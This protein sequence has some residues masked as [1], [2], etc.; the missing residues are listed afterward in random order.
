MYSISFTVRFWSLGSYQ[1]KRFHGVRWLHETQILFEEPSSGVYSPFNKVQL[2]DVHVYST[3]VGEG[4]P[5]SRD[6]EVN[7]FLGSPYQPWTQT[8]QTLSPFSLCFWIL[9]KCLF[10]VC[11]PCLG[12]KRVCVTVLVY[13]SP[14]VPR[15]RNG[16]REAEGGRLFANVIESCVLYLLVPYFIRVT[17]KNAYSNRTM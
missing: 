15:R 14:N 10:F 9:T 16:S 11:S 4:V 3:G 2:Y 7:W 17:H 8:S 12:S 1:I 5:S 6:L 13:P